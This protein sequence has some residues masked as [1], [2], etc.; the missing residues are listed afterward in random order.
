MKKT[1]F[2]LSLFLVMASCHRQQDPVVVAQQFL[3]AFFT[4]DFKTAREYADPVL[5]D[6]LDKTQDI[7]DS[8]TEEEQ[9]EVTGYLSTITIEVERP[10]DIDKDTVLL[11]YKVDFSR[12]PQPGQAVITLR[13]EGTGWRVCAL[14]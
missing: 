10:V 13:K 7:L 8:L 5:Y 4:S 1:I 3:E 11:S 14:D 9:E 2:I 6:I 12:L